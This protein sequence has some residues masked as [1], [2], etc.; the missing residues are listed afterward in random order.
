MNLRLRLNLEVDKTTPEHAYI[1]LVVLRQHGLFVHEH[2]Q[3][4]IRIRL[5][6]L[7]RTCD[8]C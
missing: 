5:D 6:C 7:G 1:F 8:F 3:K 4:Q 2:L